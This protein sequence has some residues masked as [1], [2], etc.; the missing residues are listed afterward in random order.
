MAKKTKCGLKRLKDNLD[1]ISPLHKTRTAKNRRDLLK[2]A[3]P[4]QIL[5]VCECIKNVI[6]KKVPGITEKKKTFIKK[7]R[8][9][10]LALVKDRVPTEKRRKIIA[11]KG[12]FLP[13]LLAPVLGIAG[14]L[15]GNL[16][17]G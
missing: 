1:F 6:N 9:T 8:G 15:I 14:S 12:G 11:Q 10:I 13:A 4:E 2:I 7:H 17:N 16:I 5:T 3:S